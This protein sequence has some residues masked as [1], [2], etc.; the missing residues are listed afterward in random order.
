MEINHTIT[1]DSIK[2]ITCNPVYEDGKL[3]G[4]CIIFEEMNGDAHVFQVE[5]FRA[6]SLASII[7]RQCNGG[8]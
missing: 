2:D 8:R 6:K 5:T 4:V 3:A 7:N 1:D